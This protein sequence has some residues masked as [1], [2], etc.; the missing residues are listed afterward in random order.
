MS[1]PALNINTAK[2]LAAHSSKDADSVLYK[3]DDGDWL[4]V[5][6][7]VIDSWTESQK[8]WA[9]SSYTRQFPQTERF[10]KL[11]YEV[12]KNK[13]N[14]VNVLP[15]FLPPRK[16]NAFQFWLRSNLTRLGLI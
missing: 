4:E 3:T 14:D 12:Y 1:T 6:A 16:V 8:R 7:Y 2:R 5:P 10:V 15:N 11:A 13:A 9:N